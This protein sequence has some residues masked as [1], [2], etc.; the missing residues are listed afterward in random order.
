M[1]QPQ[2]GPLEQALTGAPPMEPEGQD[3]LTGLLMQLL[4]DPQARAQVEA[5]LAAIPAEGGMQGG[6]P[7][8]SQLPMSPGM[9]GGMPGG[10]PY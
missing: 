7:G 10:M 5:I 6:M 8:M 4:S 1:E 3:P 9:G 2:I